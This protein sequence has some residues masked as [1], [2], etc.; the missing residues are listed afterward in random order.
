MFK[1]LSS[2]G[3][4]LKGA[5]EIR[6]Q[7]E[8]IQEELRHKRVEGLAGGGMVAVE[9]NG[10]QEVVRCRIDP[11]LL[12]QSNGEL[13]EALVASAVGQ[14]LEKSKGLAAEQMSRLVGGL[15]IP[16]LSDAIQQFGSLGPT[17][18]SS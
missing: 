3:S 2:L 18:G 9:M 5:Q 6:A 14:A 8:R 11:E 1:G 12:V 10:R 7:M 13:L 4:L 17:A 15:Q 16:G